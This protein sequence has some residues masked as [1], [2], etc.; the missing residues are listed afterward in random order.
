MFQPELE[1]FKIINVLGMHPGGMSIEDENISSLES[2][3]IKSPLTTFKFDSNVEVLNGRFVKLEVSK[4]RLVV[5]W[6]TSKYADCLFIDNIFDLYLGLGIE[7]GKIK[8]EQKLK[9][10]SDTFCGK[11]AIIENCILTICHGTD[12]THGLLTTS[13]LFENE[14]L[15]IQWRDYLRKRCRDL[16][17]EQ[18]SYF[19]FWRR[20]FTKIEK[21]ILDDY[22][23]VETLTEFILPSIKLKDERKHLESVLLCKV[24]Q[25]LNKKKISI[26]YLSSPEFQFSVYKAT[27]VRDDVNEVFTKIFRKQV[28]SDVQVHNYLKREHCDPRLNEVLFPH[29]CMES[30]K[31]LLSTYELSNANGLTFE[32]YLNFLLSTEN[33]LIRRSYMRLKSEDMNEPLSHYYINSSHNTYLRGKQMK[34][35]SSV[36]MYRFVLLL[37]CRSVELDCWDGPN[38]EPIITHG[39]QTIFFCST[40]LFKDVIKAIAETAFVNSDYPVILSFENHCS[41]KQQQVMARHCRNILGDLLLT[42]TLSDYPIKSG[43]K[44]PSPNLLKR[45]ILIKNKKFDKSSEETSMEKHE[46]EC[47]HNNNIMI[48]QCKSYDETN[49]NEEEVSHVFIDDNIQ[50]TDENNPDII[51][52]VYFDKNENMINR[53]CNKPA[54]LSCSGVSR[55]DSVDETSHVPLHVDH[56]NK[57]DLSNHHVPSSSGVSAD[58]S[59]LVNY[60]RAMGKLTSFVDASNKDISSELYSMNEVKAIELLKNEGEQFVEHNKRQITRVFPKGSRIDSTINFQTADLPY[61][62]NSSFFEVNGSCG[63]VLKPQNMR[64]ESMKFD[65]FE[66]NQVENVVPNSVRVTIISGQMLGL[67]TTKRP[68]LVYV[69]ADMYGIPKDS[70]KKPFRSKGVNLQT[71]NTRFSTSINDE[72]CQIVFDKII[73][74]SL[75]FLRLALLDEN[76]RLL[77]Q[78]IIPIS[79]LA[80]G[81]KHVMLRNASNRYIGPVSLFAKFEVLDYVA[82]EHREIVIQL[83]NP[84]A[85]VSKIKTWET[86]LEDPMGKSGTH[87]F[88]GTSKPINDSKNTS[89]EEDKKKML[90]VFEKVGETNQAHINRMLSI[91][92]LRSMKGDSSSS[93]SD[94]IPSSKITSTDDGDSHI[95]LYRKKQ[96]SLNSTS[97][98]TDDIILNEK[99]KT[100]VAPSKVIIDSKHFYIETMNLYYPEIPSYF[101]RKDIRKKRKMFNKKYP[102]FLSTI[103]IWNVCGLSDK[104]RF[105]QNLKKI[106]S[107]NEI[108]KYEKSINKIFNKTIEKDMKKI[109][110]RLNFGY[111]SELTSILKVTHNDRRNELEMNAKIGNIQKKS[112]EEVSDKYIKM[113]IENGRALIQAKERRLKEIDK[114][115]SEIKQII[116]SNNDQKL[117]AAKKFI[118]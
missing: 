53:E 40:I 4:D 96:R 85:A 52:Q 108:E 114:K 27:I 45:K 64:K 69:E 50:S 90:E 103:E 75:A 86:A 83:Q 9:N 87:K 10:F 29:H 68:L 26:E 34:G 36:A 79:G 59:N 101:E 55:L 80:P 104:T 66:I 30:V 71:F 76:N 81:Y 22:I 32:G 14:E 56:T 89:K 62:M 51:R 6:R 84:I 102:N 38:N 20:L 107:L 31:K 47:L 23:S 13:F 5:G 54:K 35:R 15:A 113:G 98:T 43:V 82:K 78:R 110:K 33:T 91:T 97:E 2:V 65:P 24:P 112:E 12:F 116:F 99:P 118:E 41:L 16:N 28:A 21:S 67:L 95:N 61:Q 100:S 58:L 74:P 42:E 94:T 60:V 73:M 111:K 105:S 117:G 63:Y 115:F 1:F 72:N 70:S 25:F 8:E 7:S 37:G 44:L 46:D 48:Q 92:K 49:K 88:S 39:P 93:I 57:N 77:G 3:D 109:Y 17:Q 18:K 11:G 106:P 19:Y